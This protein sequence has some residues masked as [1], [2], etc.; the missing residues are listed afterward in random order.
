MK[1]F[2][3][4]ARAFWRNEDGPTATEYAVLLALIIVG[5]LATMSQFG[6][7]VDS[8]YVTIATAFGQ[9]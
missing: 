6:A 7:R 2:I 1:A 5:V 8:I 4:K 9:I 3:Q